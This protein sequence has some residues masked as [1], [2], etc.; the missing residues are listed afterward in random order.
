MFHAILNSKQEEMYVYRNSEARSSNNCSREKAII[1]T[2][3]ECV[4]VALV[5]QHA[6][7]MSR[8]IICGLS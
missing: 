7:R 3:T 1:I 4:F 2:Y 6:V 5:I 8:I